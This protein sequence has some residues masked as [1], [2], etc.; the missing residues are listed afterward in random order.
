M[1]NEKA[2]LHKNPDRNIE[3]KYEKYIPQYRLLGIDPNK[4]ESASVP[5]DTA[6]SK[7]GTLDQDNPRLRQPSIRQPY[8]EAIESP[9]GRG[10]GP[11]PNV[12]NNLEHTWSGVDGEIID[13]VFDESIDPDKQMIDNNDFVSA[14]NF[15]TLSQA[16]VTFLDET[17]L[18][19]IIDIDNLY[20]SLQ[21]MEE[22]DYI[23]LISGVII[24]SGLL[25]DIQKQ[26][27]DFIFGDHELCDG[28][29]VS[30]DDILVL[31]RIKINIGVFLA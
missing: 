16:P 13:D 20:D 1:S 14:E 4:M 5:K 15:G 19:N 6:I 29:P 23:L 2:K 7:S 9:I 11:V 30:V 31:K 26:V 17:D 21:K 25:V 8:A 18:Q 27:K 28:N 24:N 10:K 12:G 3:E 22:E